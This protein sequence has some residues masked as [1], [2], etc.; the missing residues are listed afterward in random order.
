[1]GDHSALEF[2]RF[3]PLRVTSCCSGTNFWGTYRTDVCAASHWTKRP[4]DLRRYKYDTV[5]EVLLF[6]A[7]LQ[8]TDNT[9]LLQSS[10]E[11]SYGE[12]SPGRQYAESMRPFVLLSETTTHGSYSDS[13]NK[14]LW[15]N[16]YFREILV[17]TYSN[18][19]RVKHPR[20]D[21]DN[22]KTSHDG[23]LR[24]EVGR[25]SAVIVWSTYASEG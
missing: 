3:H 12:W 15:V 4:E 23:A 14:T 22:T 1:M 24:W 9:E 7:I 19:M 5:A 13:A 20:A 2:K 16:V 10:S 17:T 21:M 6:N 18:R 11:F 8:Q 25:L